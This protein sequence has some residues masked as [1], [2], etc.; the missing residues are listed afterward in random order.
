MLSCLFLAFCHLGKSISV[1][2]SLHTIRLPKLLGC[3]SFW[4]KS[5]TNLSCMSPWAGADRSW[6]CI[7]WSLGQI[8][9]SPFPP[10]SHLA[11]SAQHDITASILLIITQLWRFWIRAG[12]RSSC[13]EHRQKDLDFSALFSLCVCAASSEGRLNCVLRGSW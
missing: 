4:L 13:W 1:M 6:A 3:G 12:L 9:P 11:M 7:A 8:N 10:G 5:I 2:R